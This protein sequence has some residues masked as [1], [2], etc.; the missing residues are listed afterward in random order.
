MA[1][2]AVFVH[3]AHAH[4]ARRWRVKWEEGSLV[5]INDPTPY[6]YGRAEEMGCSIT[7]SESAPEN[8]AQKLVRLGTRFVLGFDLV[9]AIRNRKAMME[10]DIVWTHTESQFLGAAALMALTAGAERP[11]LLGQTVWLLDDWPRLGALRQAIIRHLMRKVDILTVHS[12]L[13]LAASREIFPET[14]TELVK[15]G[16]PTEYHEEPVTKPGLPFRVLCV[17]NDR[18]RDWRTVISA[19]RGKKDVELTIISQTADP[20]LVHGIENAH[21]RSVANNGELLQAYRDANALV[22]PLLPN[23][24][25]SG[26][27]V[28]QEAALMGVPVIASRVGGLDAYFDDTEVR[29]VPPRDPEAISAAIDRMMDRPDKALELARN[30]QRRILG[31]KLGCQTYVRRH[32]ELSQELLADRATNDRV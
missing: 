14:R 7:F 15:F 26:S 6:G 11:R 19:V 9:H 32:V 27:T 2:I 21:I 28:M 12:P 5:G 13:N 23:L 3:L 20:A 1:K 31:G 8:I 17:G 24:H 4:D 10:A 18:H 25:V 30:A 22:M 16:I 29:Y